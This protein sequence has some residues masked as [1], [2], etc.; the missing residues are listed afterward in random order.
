M[1]FGDWAE[2]KIFLQ[3]KI[4]Q[5]IQDTPHLVKY[6]TD[7]DENNCMWT[8][9]PLY[10]LTRSSKYE[11]QSQP[12]KDIMPFVDLWKQEELFWPLIV[13]GNLHT[14][15]FYHGLWSGNESW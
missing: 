4:T 15:E 1:F 2:T 10:N 14:K 11:A 12:L 6:L 7:L 13:F 8:M 5:G 9:A 3:E